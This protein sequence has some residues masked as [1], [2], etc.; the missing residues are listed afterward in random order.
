[1]IRTRWT[2][3][4]RCGTSAG[5]L[6]LQA[7]LIQA[8][9]LVVCLPVRAAAQGSS[10]EHCSA[11]ARAPL[12]DGRVLVAQAVA[13]G[14]FRTP[15]AGE[16]PGDASLPAFCR[17]QVRLTPAPGS[18]VRVEVWLPVSGWNGRF[19]G[20]GNR[21]WGGAINYALLKDAL[22]AGYAA[23]STDTGHEGRGASF[24]L[25]QPEKVIDSGYRA[26]HLM[27]VAGKELVSR[28]Y[29]R[30]ADRSYFNGCSLGGRQALSEIQRYPG[31]YDGVVAGSPAHNLSA[32]YSARLAWARTAHRSAASV[33]PQ[34]KADLLHKAALAACDA[35]DGVK[36][37]VIAEPRSCRFDPKVLQC[38]GGDAAACL[39]AEQVETA[40]ALYADVRHPVTN[41]IL[42]AGLMPG[43]ERRWPAVAGAEPDDNA[44]E[45]F[46]FVVLE[47][48]AWDWQGADFWS[49]VD[50]AF[51]KTGPVL[52][53]VDP[54]IGAFVQRGGRLLM[55]HG[56]A[57]PQTPAG[58]TIAYRRAVEDRIGKARA[59]E[60]IRLFMAPGVG[61][62]SGGDGPDRFDPVAALVRWVED[63]VAPDRIEAALV[64]DGK[65][66]RTRPLCT[67]GAVAV[68]DGRG[69]TNLAASFSCVA[70]SAPAPPVP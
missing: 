69:D 31:D 5:S 63:G 53:A 44:L 62:C 56:W 41:E 70:Q 40:L 45:F 19:Q 26:V 6:R 17:V 64:R 66:V 11:L 15:G 30:P 42:S 58:N 43:S 38:P 12:S 33:I 35:N 65:T 57:D 48:P 18:D 59:A 52:D 27:T 25:G 49:A 14:A 51:A 32:L 46:R 21:G 37:D 54:D 23:A 24:A 55:Y 13:A 16:T 3:G 67:E 9:L 4:G 1:M 7:V 29:G 8:A 22:G 39:T 50:R 28:F 47:N 10:V 2:N 20:V 68:W 34:A 36:D 61:H 60:S